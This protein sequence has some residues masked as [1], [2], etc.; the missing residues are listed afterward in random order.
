[1][2]SM[3]ARVT[4]TRIAQLR[5]GEQIFDTEVKGFG[6]RCQKRGVSYF[7]KTRFLGQQRFLTI[8]RHGQPWTPET[9]RKEA[10]RLLGQIVAGIDPVVEKKTKIG[11]AKKDG[12]TVE[13]ASERFLATHGKKLKPT[14]LDVYQR[15]VRLFILP[16]LGKLRVADV[17]PADV[18]NAHAAW[19]E[20][21]RSANHALAVLS[22]M[23][24]WAEDNGLRRAD[25]N[26][27]KRIS[28]YRERQRQ[29]FLSSEELVRLGQALDE[30]EHEGDSATHTIAAIRLL[31]L[32]GARLNEILT[33]KWSY[34]DYDRALLLLPDS[35]TGQKAIALNAQ[36][37]EILR[38]LPRELNNPYVIVG[39]RSGTHLVNIQKPWR[40]IRERAE[41][42]DVRIHDL[43][44]TFASV[45][46]ASGASL[47]MIG[48]LLGHT[49]AQTTA[50]YAHLAEDPMRQ[51]NSQ[52]GDTLAAA[53]APRRSATDD[54]A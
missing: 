14:T 39:R 42:P 4:L 28:R 6:A 20:R 21:P 3:T 29:R 11:Q 2:A 32:T 45:A 35:K 37:I 18:S 24:V 19:S 43:R 5:A 7:L 33:L 40:R 13:E 47:H 26:P 1:M 51:L 46:A 17:K 38:R 44:H 53:L 8:G 52:V 27:C 49:Q 34:V 30:L 54:A 48:K 25:T 16:S 15:M 22:K 12:V 9:A 41:L 50:R 23:M 10:R 31:L 36:A